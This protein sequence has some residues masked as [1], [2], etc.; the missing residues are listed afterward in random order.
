M[1]FIKEKALF[2]ICLIVFTSF[3]LYLPEAEAQQQVCCERT[4]VGGFC[5]YT[6]ESQCDTSVSA[7][8]GR[9][10]FAVP[11]LCENTNYCTLG[12]CFDSDSGDCFRSTSQSECQQ[13]EGTW[14]PNLFC[15]IPQC[16]VGCCQL[17]NQAFISTL[18]KCKQVTSQYPA[19]EMQFD[20][21]IQDEYS[22]VNSVKTGDKGCCVQEDVCT[23]TTREEC[24]V[25][26]SQPELDEEGNPIAGTQQ[27]GSM[28]YDG[29]LCSHDALPCDAAKLHHKGCLDEDVYWFDSDDN[30]ENI[31]LGSSQEAKRRSYNNGFILEDSGCVAGPD[32]NS[33]GDCDYTEGTLCG[34]KDGDFICKDLNC[35]SSTS[36]TGFFSAELLGG[37]KKLGES[38]CIYDG[39]VGG[40][41]DRVGSRHF[42]GACIN[43]EEIIEGCADFREEYCTQSYSNG[44]PTTNFG[45]VYFSVTDLLPKLDW[46]SSPLSNVFS[47]D[48]YSEAACKPNRFDSCA[49]CNAFSST[50][51]IKECC[52]ERAFRDCF[53]LKAGVTAAEGTCV[54]DV[55][56]GLRFWSDEMSVLD[57]QTT[58]TGDD[59]DEQ[60]TLA[61]PSSPGDATCSQAN[62]ECEVGFSRTTFSGWKCGYNCHCLKEDTF[63]AAHAVCRSLGDCGAYFN[64]QGAFTKNGFDIKVEGPKGEK[65][66]P[67]NLRRKLMS[68]IEDDLLRDARVKQPKEGGSSDEMSLGDFFG[69]SAV[70]LGIIGL[71][72]LIGVGSSVGFFGGLLYGPLAA[73]STFTGLL[74]LPFGNISPGVALWGAAPS[75]AAT[76]AGV[77][78]MMGRGGFDVFKS[79]LTEGAV[80]PKGASLSGLKLNLGAGH[81]LATGQTLT[82][83][84]GN[85]AGVTFS[86]GAQVSITNAVG[87]TFTGTVATAD[88]TGAQALN[89][90]TVPVEDV[91]AGLGVEANTLATTEGIS[92]LAKGNSLALTEGTATLT[93]GATNA[94]LDG[95]ATGAEGVTSA[96]TQLGAINP[97]LIAWGVIQVAMWVWTIYN[98][99]DLLGA[100]S[101]KGKVTFICKS[102]E[103]PDGGSQCH[104]CNEGELPCS[105]YRCRSLGKACQVVNQGT[106]EELCYNMLPNDASSPRI[107]ADK[108]AMKDLQIQ[109]QTNRGFTITERIQPFTPVSLAIITDEPAQ[110]KYSGESGTD[111]EEMQYDFGSS[112][113][114]MEHNMTFALSA[115]L[116]ADQALQ[117]TNGGE[118]T[119]YLRC[120]D[121]NG[122]TNERDYYI[123]FGIDNG[124]DLTPP[125]V[126]QTSILSGTYIASGIEAVA[127]DV[128]VNEPAQCRWDTRDLEYDMMENDFV[129]LASGYS[130]DNLGTYKCSGSLPM[131]QADPLN[132]EDNGDDGNSTEPG[133]SPGNIEN[134]FYFRCK[135]REGNKNFQ[136]Y[137]FS[138]IS[139]VS[140][141][142]IETSPE[143]VLTTGTNIELR[144]KTQGGAENGVAVCGLS[145]QNV[146]FSQMP[147]FQ[148]TEAATHTQTLL[149]LDEG[150]YV[151]YV[152]CMD[153]GGNEARSTIEFTVESDTSIPELVYVF[154]DEQLGILHITTD[155]P[156][157][158]EYA[159]S[160]FVFGQG[161]PM[162]PAGG[163]SEDHEAALQ[164]NM[165]YVI[166]CRDEFE[167]EAIFRVAS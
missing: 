86:D 108:E 135:D 46:A 53:F 95:V 122:N 13:L 4:T 11:T 94:A 103:A 91:A 45:S 17:S 154:K 112:L 107:I 33:C 158:C 61:A 50:D 142:I 15:D 88:A 55:P 82:A 85:I 111:F 70:P 132:L 166:L 57:Q 21:S 71:S 79:T 89:W 119:I 143:G 68:R 144:V 100:K 126:E 98:L 124:P 117:L 34:E 110:C 49:Q 72:G 74:T 75:Q 137:R 149:K 138:L 58:T 133:Q 24:G 152:L 67:D 162:T 28:F 164:S 26:A 52:E 36:G 62:V 150:D 96:A 66:I 92:T 78:G 99:I 56:P 25:E 155:E 104:V 120:K 77:Q 76:Q 65:A 29:Y 5:V 90:G 9:N 7:D 22:C 20:P 109:E 106:E 16:S 118:Y 128:F 157:K 140:L 148:N 43:G 19:V 153:Q 27:E 115:E 160:P 2:M 145:L 64:Y 51:L 87:D 165:I 32:D 6:D 113:F 8:F 39:V 146:G 147:A 136:S 167:N 12:C 35:D 31:F 163:F 10:F 48:S 84:G 73:L 116:A 54:P 41:R 83:Q 127:L 105:E 139:T 30:P 59:G 37:P 161:I 101:V 125:K 114:L 93:E 42:R 130:A 159:D 80:V 47:G 131:Q 60:T 97:A 18:T 38:W 23:F 1:T 121:P 3:A 44:N 69:R 141:E 134:N 102:W 14:E 63:A 129:C 81:N 151:Y 123:K 40:G 156:T